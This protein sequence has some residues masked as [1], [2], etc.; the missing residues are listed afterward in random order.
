MYILHLHDKH[1]EELVT[2][3]EGRKF[4]GKPV[5]FTT[6]MYYP[7]KMDLEHF[8]SRMRES[9]LAFKEN[10][11]HL[12]HTKEDWPENWMS[13]FLAWC[14]IEQHYS[15]ENIYRTRQID[16]IVENELQ[17]QELDDKID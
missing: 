14:E 9:L 3:Q 10:M 17:W 6:L 7:D 16:R 2:E 1:Y 15:D 11:V 4:F 5:R 12:G 13:T 8:T